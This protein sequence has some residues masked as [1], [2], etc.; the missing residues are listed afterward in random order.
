MAE[1]GIQ[2]LP[3]WP[4]YSPDLN[5]QE[6]V[7][8]WAEDEFREHELK[9][10]AFDDFKKRVIKAVRNY[11]SG[12]KLVKSMTERMQEVVGLKGAMISH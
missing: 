7:W 9:S 1:L 6:N 3:N 4:G 11:P 5:P 12:E 10:D 8:A 2:V